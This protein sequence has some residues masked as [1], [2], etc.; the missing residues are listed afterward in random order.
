MF[1]D[2]R[3]NNSPFKDLKIDARSSSPSNIDYTTGFKNTPKK[4]KDYDNL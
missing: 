4:H 1:Y 3:K 2:S